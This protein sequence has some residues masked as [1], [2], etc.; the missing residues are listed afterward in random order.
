MVRQALATLLSLEDDIEVVAQLTRGDE[1]LDAARSSQPDVALLD[2]EMPGGDGLEAAARLNHELPGVKVLILTTFGRP[3]FLRRALESGAVGFLLKDAPASELSAAIRGALDG[4]RVVDPELAM[5]AL[6]AGADPLTE[7]EHEVLAAA[8]DE[9]TVADIAA[10]VHLSQGTVRNQLS[11]V[12]QKLG[13]RN[14]VDAVRIAQ[15]KGWLS[16]RP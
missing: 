14:R 13:A 10:T 16:G 6:S 1:V 15:D 11:V 5:A 12:I 3:G 4:Q 7:R 8:R 9:A 2:I